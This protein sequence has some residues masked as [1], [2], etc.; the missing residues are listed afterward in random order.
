M[1]DAAALEDGPELALTVTADSDGRYRAQEVAAK[2]HQ[3]VRLLARARTTGGTADRGGA[4]RL[5]GLGRAD[6]PTAVVAQ[7]TTIRSVPARVTRPPAARR[8]PPPAA[9]RCSDR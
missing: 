8:A 9:G 4:A 5:D 7:A 6:R 2:Y 1:G 3:L